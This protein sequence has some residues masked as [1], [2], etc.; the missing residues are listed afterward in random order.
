MKF[1]KLDNMWYDF[2]DF[3]NL[4]TNCMGC[5]FRAVCMFMGRTLET[6]RAPV[7]NAPIAGLYICATAFT[8]NFTADRLWVS[9]SG[10]HGYF[11]FL[12]GFSWTDDAKFRCVGY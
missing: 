5:H 11:S 1:W 12:Y 9:L 6:R 8:D 10:Q 7:D 2:S 3:E 4:L